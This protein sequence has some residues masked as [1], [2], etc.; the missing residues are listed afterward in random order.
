MLLMMNLINK[1]KFSLSPK[2]SAL[3]ISIFKYIQH[4][5]DVDKVLKLQLKYL[6]VQLLGLNIQKLN[7]IKTYLSWQNM[8]LSPLATL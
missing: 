5:Q 3:Y 2:N 6:K 7:S 1:I 4:K 8:I